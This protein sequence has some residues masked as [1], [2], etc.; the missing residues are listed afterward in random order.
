MMPLSR[1]NIFRIVTHRVRKERESLEP[2]WRARGP[3][4]VLA[5]EVHSELTT[6]TAAVVPFDEVPPSCPRRDELL[7]RAS[8]SAFVRFYHRGRPLHN[9]TL[10]DFWN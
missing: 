3:S 5:I 6:C 4:E 2:L 10:F 7:N 9:L 1:A 8:F